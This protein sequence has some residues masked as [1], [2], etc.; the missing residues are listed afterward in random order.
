MRALARGAAVE[1]NYSAGT[2]TVLESID[3]AAVAAARNSPNCA[4]EPGLGCLTN[5]WTGGVTTR[6]VST[7]TLQPELGVAMTD[8]DGNPASKLSVCF[9]PMGRSFVAPDNAVPWQ[10]LTGAPVMTFTRSGKWAGGYQ[11]YVALLPNGVARMT[12]AEAK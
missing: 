10:P 8:T 9:T 3:G 4:N 5:T 2:F 11:Y 6:E 1:V 7:L 12:R